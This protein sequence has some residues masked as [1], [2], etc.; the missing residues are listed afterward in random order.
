MQRSRGMTVNV[1]SLGVM[2]LKCFIPHNDLLG[3]CCI[4]CKQNIGRKYFLGAVHLFS[5]MTG[6]KLSI[7]P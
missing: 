4:E 7:Y 6:W 3:T 5:V 2:S 1:L